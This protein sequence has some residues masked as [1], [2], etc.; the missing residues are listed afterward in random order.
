M[1]HSELDHRL[2]R[3][4]EPRQA[5]QGVQWLWGCRT[6]GGSF[7]RCSSESCL[8]GGQDDAPANVNVDSTD[9]AER[10]LS[11]APFVQVGMDSDDTLCVHQKNRLDEAG[12]G[13]SLQVS[14]SLGP[15]PEP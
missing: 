13:Q 11:Q 9:Q 5:R 7:R 3:F 12:S 10:R 8:G 15:S 6:A 2:V 1:S 4:V 14:A